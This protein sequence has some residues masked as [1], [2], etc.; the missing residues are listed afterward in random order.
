MC[1][2]KKTRHSLIMPM[3]RVETSQFVLQCVCVCVRACA[4][5]HA[6]ACVCVCVCVRARTR[7]CLYV[8]KRVRVLVCLFDSWSFEPSQPQRIT[9]GLNTNFTLS[10][11]YL[12]HKSSYTSH[13][14][15]SLFIFLSLIHI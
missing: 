1:S 10:P 8:Y 13:V 15:F 6:R 12:F 2:M 7:A 11:S 3:K 4:C 14:F 5:A 9:S